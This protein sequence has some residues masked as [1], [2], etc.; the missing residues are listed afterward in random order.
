MAVQKNMDARN[1][2]VAARLLGELLSQKGLPDQANLELRCKKC[3]EEKL[4][5]ATLAPTFVCPVCTSQVSAGASRCGNCARPSS[6][7]YQVRCTFH[8]LLSLSCGSNFYSSFYPGAML[9]LVAVV[10]SVGR[11]APLSVR[12]LWRAV[13]SQGAGGR[14]S[15]HGVRIWR[16]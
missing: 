15:L 9:M 16:S 11:Q 5:D 12:F 4:A 2:G 7:C 8:N 3:E 13:Q 6:F 1:F 14:Q 10:A